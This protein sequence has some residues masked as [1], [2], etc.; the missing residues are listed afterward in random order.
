MKGRLRERERRKPLAPQ[1]G[2]ETPPHICECSTRTS[3]LQFPQPDTPFWSRST[4]VCELTHAFNRRI[5]GRVERRTVAGKGETCHK[6]KDDAKLNNTH[7]DA[8]TLEAIEKQ[9]CDRTPKQPLL[10]GRLQ[11]H[12]R[13][14][15]KVNGTTSSRSAY[16]STSKTFQFGP[17]VAA[18]R[19]LYLSQIFCVCFQVWEILQFL[20][21]LCIIAMNTLFINCSVLFFFVFFT[22]KSA[23]CVAVFLAFY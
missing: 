9:K 18:H 7:L 23:L 4:F 21:C 15:H 8:Q 11:V 16:V 1:S 17:L 13:K 20:V 10:R 6:P 5:W 2:R 12:K 22:V 3:R 14:L 19:C